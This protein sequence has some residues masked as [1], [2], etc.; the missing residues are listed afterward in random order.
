MHVLTIF[1]NVTYFK[2][3]NYYYC[4]VI[5][6]C[7]EYFLKKN[8]IFVKAKR[9]YI[10]LYFNHYFPCLYGILIFNIC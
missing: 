2:Y 10:R 7:T 1:K 5:N 8:L 4:K 3:F 6:F 9:L